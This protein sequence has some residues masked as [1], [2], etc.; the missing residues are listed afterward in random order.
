MD[1]IKH[2]IIEKQYN[3]SNIVWDEKNIWNFGYGHKC[4]ISWKNSFKIFY[5]PFIDNIS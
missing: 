4:N 1:K 3:I 5:N 2:K